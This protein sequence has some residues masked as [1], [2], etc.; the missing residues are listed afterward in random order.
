M[1][2]SVPQTTSYHIFLFPFRYEVKTG[3]RLNEDWRQV[4]DYFETSALWKRQALGKHFST[5]LRYNEFH[6]FHPFAQGVLFDQNQDTTLYHFEYELPPLATYDIELTNGKVF[7]L[8]ID[9]IVLKC[10]RTG[11]GILSFHLRN[12]DTETSASDILE[13]NQFGRRIYPPIM[14]EGTELA[15]AIRLVPDKISLQG[16]G[17]QIIETPFTCNTLVGDAPSPNHVLALFPKKFL[18]HYSIVPALDD[19][20][21]VMGWAVNETCLAAC[22][23]N[24]SNGDD[25]RTN[26]YWY[27]YVYVDG[28]GAEERGLQNDVFKREL[29]EKS[30]YARWLGVGTIYGV[31]RYAFMGLLGEEVPP[32]VK[33]TVQTF[34]YR[35]VELCLLQRASL[36]QF[37]RRITQI[38]HE[39]DGRNKTRLAAQLNRDY[40]HYINSIYFAEITPQEQGIELYDL[41]QSSLCIDRDN[42]L[43]NQEIQELHH[44]LS[45]EEEKKRSRALDHLTV[46]G[47][48]FIIP[49]FIMGYFALGL[50]DQQLTVKE[51][52]VLL[53]IIIPV[54]LASVLSYVAFRYSGQKRGANLLWLVVGVLIV[55]ILAIP[56][57]RKQL[58]PIVPM[59]V[60]PDTIR[61]G[62]PLLIPLDSNRTL[63]LD[64]ETIY[65]LSP[66]HSKK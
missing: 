28:P 25:Y 54:L 40:L 24:H 38:T 37:S 55:F 22:Q 17:K 48:F 11:V 18:S 52:L 23:L 36:L 63:Q 61:L 65:F 43:L 3:A 59:V 45:A 47:A 4:K 51:P 66:N 1:S 58:I 21:F 39:E 49:S 29:I 30:T 31:C 32:H 33:T 15:K 6:Y 46:L 7:S 41:L 64:P 20:M 10:Y 44:F 12:T 50:I 2:T 42:Q 60:P 56:F 8:F 5:P 53:S 26:D 34:Y 27:R 62:A 57:C 14:G 9:R 19:R 35:M 13:I 16:F